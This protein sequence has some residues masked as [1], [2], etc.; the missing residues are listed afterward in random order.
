MA[1][2]TWAAGLRGLMVEA[3]G[4]ESAVHWYGTFGQILLPG[5]VTGALFGWGWWARRRWTTLA[6]LA[7]PLAVVASPDTVT[8]ILNG[9]VPFADG[10][11]GGALAL[12]LFGI[13]G[14]Y[15]IAGRGARAGRIVCGLLALASGPAWAVAAASIS[16]V[17]AVDTPRGAW[18]AVLFAGSVATLAIGCAVPLFR[19]AAERSVDQGDEVSP[20]TAS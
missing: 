4:F 2:L 9:D 5:L 13:A 11:G 10:I 15:A 3:A 1:G 20:S 6:P 17:L 16:P 12:P 8:T 7:F 19:A 18:V 14:G